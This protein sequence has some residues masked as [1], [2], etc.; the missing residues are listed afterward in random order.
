MAKQPTLKAGYDKARAANL[1]QAACVRVFGVAAES[2]DRDHETILWCGI[3][4]DGVEHHQATDRIWH[5]P[6]S[7]IV[8]SGKADGVGVRGVSWYDLRKD[9]TPVEEVYAPV[10]LVHVARM[11]LGGR[12][13]HLGTFGDVPITIEPTSTTIPSSPPVT[14]NP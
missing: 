13:G 5:L 6:K 4:I 2:I 7:D 9:S 14:L 10:S 11:R 1:R 12:F 3:G 8:A